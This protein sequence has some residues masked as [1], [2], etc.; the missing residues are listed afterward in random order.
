MKKKHL[1]PTNLSVW[2]N[3]KLSFALRMSSGCIYITQVQTFT[4][5]KCL[6]LQCNM[7]AVVTTSSNPMALWK[8]LLQCTQNFAVFAVCRSSVLHYWVT[9]VSKT[10]ALTP[11]KLSKKRRWRRGGDREQYAQSLLSLPDTPQSSCRGDY[12]LWR[13]LH[14]VRTWIGSLVC[15]GRESEGERAV[16]SV[17][18]A[19]LTHLS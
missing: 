8:F 10:V 4:T 11:V 12:D 14:V 5:S 17:P 3:L 18:A 16:S 15:A 9:R 6:S 7:A 19:S 1:N 2:V 13:S